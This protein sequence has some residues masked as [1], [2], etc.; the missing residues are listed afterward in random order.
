MRRETPR[1]ARR[2]LTDGP[3]A[4]QSSNHPSFGRASRDLTGRSGPLGRRLTGPPR[5]GRARM[6]TERAAVWRRR[7]PVLR[8][9]LA[10]ALEASEASDSRTARTGASWPFHWLSPECTAASP[11]R[12]DCSCLGIHCL[13]PEQ[14]LSDDA[15]A[16]L[17]RPATHLTSG[18]PRCREHWHSSDLARGAAPGSQDQRRRIAEW[19]ESSQLLAAQS[20]S[21]AA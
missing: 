2:R 7:S 9:A 20:R 3:C 14:P 13:R 17:L 11:W 8:V 10:T 16:A 6:R 4:L 12:A 19:N 5:V 15:H 21:R 18:M 1:V